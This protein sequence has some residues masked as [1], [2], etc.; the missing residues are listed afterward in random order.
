MSAR[1]ASSGEV[2]VLASR[3]VSSTSSSSFR[4]STEP[5]PLYHYPRRG[6]L[7]QL[8][9]GRPWT[10]RFAG[11]RGRCPAGLVWSS[12]AVALPFAVNNHIYALR[13]TIRIRT[14]L[15][16]I[17]L[18]YFRASPSRP[19]SSSPSPLYVR[20]PALCP[21]SSVGRL[22]GGRGVRARA[23]TYT[24]TH[25]VASTRPIEAV[26]WQHS[27]LVRRAMRSPVGGPLRTP[28]SGRRSM[29]SGSPRAT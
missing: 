17:P 20:R 22:R 18:R 5:V 8:F 9:A 15:S 10:G 3:P 24:H 2:F 13:R 26:E 4:L 21:L 25:T 12:L 11:S 19:G 27:A 14:Y 7:Y 29:R 1:L 23:H 16:L 6:A 28:I